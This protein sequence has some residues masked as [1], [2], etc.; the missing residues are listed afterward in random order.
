MKLR[1]Y[2]CGFVLALFCSGFSWAQ[3]APAAVSVSKTVVIHAGHLLDVKT[4]K[5]LSNQTI[6]IQG[7]KIVSVGS[8]S[9]IPASA[10]VGASVGVQVIDLSVATVLPLSLIHI[11]NSK[12]A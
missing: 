5:M 8:D 9:Q 6:V 12:T 2:V 11:S 4:G 10:Q 1:R 7:D 3:T